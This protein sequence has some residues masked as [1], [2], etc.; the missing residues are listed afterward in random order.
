MCPLPFIPHSFISMQFLVNLLQN[1]GY[2]HPAREM[3]LTLGTPES[4]TTSFY[5]DLMQLTKYLDRDKELSSY[6]NFIY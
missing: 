1:N 3:A 4:A 5:V 6:S 2:E